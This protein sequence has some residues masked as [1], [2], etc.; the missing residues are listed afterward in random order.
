MG[1]LASFGL[2]A[3]CAVTILVSALAVSSFNSEARQVLK[4][5]LDGSEVPWPIAK[6]F[7]A[8]PIAAKAAFVYDATDNIIYFEKSADTPLPLA[9]L[10]K[11][12]TGLVA[13]ELAPSY[14][15]IEIDA[16]AL[17]AEGDTGLLPDEIWRL[18]DLTGFTLAASSNDG[19]RA[20]AN[21]IGS[22]QAGQ[23]N[24]ESGRDYFIE[25]MN[26][27]A[28]ALSLATMHFENET[29]LDL[30]ETVPGAVGNARDMAKLF[31]YA[32]E[33]HR[34][35]F[36]ATKKQNLKI[37]SRSQIPHQAT[38]TNELVGSIDGL[39]ASKTGYTDL[40]G[41]NLAM[42]VTISAPGAAAHTYVVVIMG[43]TLSGR[44]SDATA[45]LE[46]LKK[47]L[48]TP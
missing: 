11:I 48:S 5:P 35:I 40:A 21:V 26:R 27:K 29:G 25:L 8:V 19:A 32:L 45:L 10:A 9:S 42:A 23:S 3:V 30:S 44:S 43:S 15:L 34:G 38:N 16:G 6:T 33:H 24:I 2:L 36:D 17:S 28:S 14:T 37:I 22:W 31:S 12:M 20:I 7:P 46:A 13:A 4:V 41:G 1:K 18:G 39:L 47:H